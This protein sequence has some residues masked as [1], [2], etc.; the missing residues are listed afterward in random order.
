MKSLVCMTKG[1]KN[2]INENEIKFKDLTNSLVRFNKNDWGVL[3]KDDTELQSELLK[4]EN[5]KL[6]NMFMGS[7]VSN[8]TKFW[9]ISE[10]DYLIGTLITTIL[11]PEEY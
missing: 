8:K 5:S 1:I 6:N 4:E 2:C 10:Y 7:Y 11:L 3:C 9:I